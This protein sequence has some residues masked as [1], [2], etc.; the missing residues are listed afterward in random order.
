MARP[1]LRQH[2]PC[3][4]SHRQACFIK[5]MHMRP[6]S[7][8][9]GGWAGLLFVSLLW[10]T[11]LPDTVNTGALRDCLHGA[12]TA[13]AS[14]ITKHNR[15]ASVM[16]HCWRHGTPAILTKQKST[17]KPLAIAG[18]MCC[19]IKFGETLFSFFLLAFYDAPSCRENA[20][21]PITNSYSPRSPR[22]TGTNWT[23]RCRN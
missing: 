16:L 9:Y 13:S 21:P 10:Q 3:F 2:W 8:F 23:P 7:C 20:R 6:C 22:Y 1:A 19:P 12:D 5:I 14:S 17:I 11:A 18:T 15:V 4:Y